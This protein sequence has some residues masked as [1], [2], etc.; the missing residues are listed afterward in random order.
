MRRYTSS[1]FEHEVV[2]EI[3]GLGDGWVYGKDASCLS[4]HVCNGSP[5]DREDLTP[6]R[7]ST[8]LVGDIGRDNDLNNAGGRA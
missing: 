8:V 1:E 3:R 5:V 2:S 4:G 7:G 6:V